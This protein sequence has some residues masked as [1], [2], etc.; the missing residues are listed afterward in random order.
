M[1]RSEVEQLRMQNVRAGEYA[2]ENIRL[3]ELLGYKQSAT[4]FDLVMA[5]VIGRETATWTRMIVIDRGTQ[6]GVRK[7]MAVVT[8]RGLVGVVTDAGIFSPYDLH[9]YFADGNEGEYARKELVI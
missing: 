8:A 5:H 4:Q 2:A 1:L 9:R 3:R 6:H 7:N